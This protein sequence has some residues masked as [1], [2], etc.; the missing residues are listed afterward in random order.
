MRKIAF[1]TFALLVIGV[2]CLATLPDDLGAQQQ[3]DAV[4]TQSAEQ[5]DAESPTL[6]LG[7]QSSF[8]AYGLSLMVDVTEVA[9]LQGIVGF[10]GTLNT[11]AARGLYRFNRETYHDFYGY[12]MVGGWSYAGIE[13][14]PGG[15][16]GA[17]F[18]GDIRGLNPEGDLPPLFFN[19]ELGLGFV[20][21]DQAAYNFSTLM[22]GVGVHYRI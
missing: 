2:L 19:F 9:S 3:A 6:G 13:T 5:Q 8:P 16:V 21:F 7:F 15:G 10:F 11:Y 12:G 1:P 17:G 18:E 4:Q 22:F 14:V 20:N